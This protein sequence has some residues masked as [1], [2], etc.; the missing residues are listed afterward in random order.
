LYIGGR[1]LILRQI[2]ADDVERAVREFLLLWAPARQEYEAQ[3]EAR[4]QTLRTE[5]RVVQAMEPAWKSALA[6]A[7]PQDRPPAPP[8]EHVALPEHLPALITKEQLCAFLG[9]PTRTVE[10]KATLITQLSEILRNDTETK[11]LF[12]EVFVEETA[13]EPWELEKLLGCTASERKRWVNDGKLV[14]LASRSVRKSGR[15]LVYPIFD[16]RDIANITPE[17]I[18]RFREEHASLVAMRRKTGARIAQ[19]SKARYAEARKL[20]FKEVEDTF[21]EWARLGSPELA[22]VLHLAFWTQMASR[23]A[24]ENQAKS[25]QATKYH[26]LY[27]QRMDEWYQCKE[28]A[29]RVLARSSYA[30][31]SYYRPEEA[32]KIELALCNNHYELLREGYYEDKWDFYAFH[33]AEIHACSACHVSISPEYYA[34]Y[35]VEISAPSCP[36]C[37][38]SFHVP[39]PRGK[40]FLPPAETLPRVSHVEQ[41]GLFRFGR[42]LYAEEKMLYRE[43]DVAVHFAQALAE[44]SSLPGISGN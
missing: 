6:R 35:A 23:W 25:L 11:A 19:E 26:A 10:R 42:R 32:D 36:A 7:S 38:F 34:L 39:Q 12:F 9:L 8:C 1:E 17:T 13:V 3:L 44:A 30:R 43:K 14:P 22:V 15:E 24:K 33:Q 16:R 31:L 18:A 27:R 21:G 40:S 20:A 2:L 5:T 4:H 37:T 29:L 28:E 41:E